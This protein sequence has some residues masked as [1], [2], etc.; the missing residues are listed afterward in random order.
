M[1]P[2]NWL[3]HITTRHCG[4]FN[5][6]GHTPSTKPVRQDV[7]KGYRSLQ[8]SAAKPMARPSRDVRQNHGAGARPSAPATPRLRGACGRADEMRGPEPS[9]KLRLTV[10]QC[11]LSSIC[12]G[13]AQPHN[14]T[15]FMT[16]RCVVP[17][18]D[19]VHRRD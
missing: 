13:Q 18:A 6:K 14:V 1:V 3:L 10:A 19:T 17:V 7:L 9:L 5:I 12:A 4:C 11:F 16:H 2:P 15:R 8:P